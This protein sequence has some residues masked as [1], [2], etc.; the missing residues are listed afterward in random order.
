MSKAAL[1]VIAVVV[2]LL[3]LVGMSSLFT[4]SEMEQ[5]IVM[6]F[7][8]PRRV[9]N[10]PGIKVKIPF[11]QDVQ[12]Y[13][14]R[15][16]N[17]DPPFETMLLSDQKRVLIDSFVRY[18]I[19]DPLE[20]FKTV[21]SEQTARARLATI[22]NS[23]VRDVVGNSTLTKVLSDERIELLGRIVEKLNVQASKFG[24]KI[25]DVRFR[26]TDLPDEVSER[27][28]ARMRSERE[29]EA[30]EFRAEGFEVAQF[31]KADADRQAI[32][33]KAD[34][35]RKAETLRGQGEG[36]RTRTLNDAYGQDPEFFSFYRSMQA[37]E[38]A[39]ADNS[40]YLVLSPDSDFFE[41]FN[42]SGSGVEAQQ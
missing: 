35:K 27:V 22:T 33:L 12:Y 6:Q 32:V 19:S 41:F 30:K 8:E 42:R 16:L 23:V 11:V 24:I 17:L 7:G 36:Q 9:I 13:E 10:E 2:F 20:F 39:L 29:R 5:A 21:R 31:I 1:L 18:Q 15:V 38:A 25:V 40:T 3:G 26:R 28:Y 34:A 4:V 14:K 37:Y